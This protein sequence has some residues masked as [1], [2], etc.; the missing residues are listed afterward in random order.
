MRSLPVLSGLQAPAARRRARHGPLHEVRH[1]RGWAGPEVARMAAPGHAARLARDRTRRP[2]RASVYAV[3]LL[4]AEARAALGSTKRRR[5]KVSVGVYRCRRCQAGPRMAR[6][7][8]VR[9]VAVA[10]WPRQA[11]DNRWQPDGARSG[12]V[13]GAGG[14]RTGAGS[15][16]TARRARADRIGK[17][18]G[19]GGQ[20]R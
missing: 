1:R 16:E 7:S 17:L 14:R 19:D 9:G 4:E 20:P 6:S 11:H 2:D 15:L 18:L 10:C 13:T 3:Q 8:V 12:D 5:R